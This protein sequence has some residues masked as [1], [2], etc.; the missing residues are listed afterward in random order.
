VPPADEVEPID[1]MSAHA[2][3]ILAAVSANEALLSYRNTS[4]EQIG[5]KSKMRVTQHPQYCAEGM[6]FS[7][8]MHEQQ[9]PMVKFT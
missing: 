6:L 8:V 5:I 9:L 4:D 7:F 1:H 3:G 2:R